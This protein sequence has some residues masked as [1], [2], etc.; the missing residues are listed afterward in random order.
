MFQKNGAKTATFA[1]SEFTK[2]LRETIMDFIIALF[3]FFGLLNPGDSVSSEFINQ[4]QNFI[5]QHQNDSD[6]LRY[7]DSH[8]AS[9]T[10]VLVD[11][12]E[13]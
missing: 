1:L 8:Q 4:N 3:M 7:Y 13:E 6:F 5:L 11:V 9:E 12:Q 2:K 10:F